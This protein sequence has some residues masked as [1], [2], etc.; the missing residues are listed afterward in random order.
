MIVSKSQL[1]ATLLDERSRLTS[2]KIGDSVLYH[3]RCKRMFPPH[4]REAGDSEGLSFVCSIIDRRPCWIL[5]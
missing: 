3:S 4:A 5:C 2:C 1:Q